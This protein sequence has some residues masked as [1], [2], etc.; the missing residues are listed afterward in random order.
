MEESGQENENIQANESE[1]ILDSD[2]KGEE[3][4]TEGGLINKDENRIKNRINQNQN[5]GVENENV[6]NSENASLEELEDNEN[7][8]SISEESINNVG[9]GVKQLNNKQLNNDITKGDRK[10]DLENDVGPSK[11]YQ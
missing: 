10:L 8:E 11:T 2:D 6:K 4:N 3:T 9:D 1:D 7:F 5:D